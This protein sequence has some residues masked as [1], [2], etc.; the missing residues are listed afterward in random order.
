MTDKTTSQSPAKPQSPHTQSDV[1]VQQTASQNTQQQPKYYNYPSPQQG[2]MHSYYQPMMY[3]G[4]M[5]GQVPMQVPVGHT[6]PAAN[7]PAAATN[8]SAP[9]AAQQAKKAD[10]DDAKRA[11]REA[12]AKRA[13]EKKAKADAAAGIVTP[14]AQEQPK[15][16]PNPVAVV[17]PVVVEEKEEQ[18]KKEAIIEEPKKEDDDEVST[19]KSIDTVSPSTATETPITIE[20]TESVISQ[21]VEGVAEDVLKADTENVEEAENIEAGE[22]A[23]GEAEEEQE[24]TPKIEGPTLSEFLARL[25]NAKP[26]ESVYKFEYPE[27]TT[28]PAERLATRKKR[29]YDPMFLTQFAGPCC[30]FVDKEYMATHPGI[31]AIINSKESAR[32]NSKGSRGGSNKNGSIRQ[33]TIRGEYERSSRNGSK[34]RQPSKRGGRESS[35]RDKPKKEEV[36]MKIDGTPMV[37]LKPE[38][39]VPLEKSKSRWVPKSQKKVEKEVKYAPDG[40][41]VILDDDDIQ[42]KV[43]SLLNKMTLDNLDVIGDE[44]LELANQSLWEDDKNALNRVIEYTFAKAFDEPHW[45]AMYA[46]WTQKLLKEVNEDIGLELQSATGEISSIKGPNLVYRII[47]KTCQVE[48][49]KGWSNS[50]PTNEDGSPL[51]IE[52]MSDEYYEIAKAKRRGL[53]LVRFIGELY[54]LNI[55]R[56]QILTSSLKKLM[57]GE[58]KSNGD[59]YLPEDDTLETILQLLLTA[60]PRLTKSQPSV[61]A[62]VFG[63]IENYTNNEKLGARIRFKFLDLLDSYKVGWS[64]G[65]GID[66]PKTIK[67]IHAA[68]EQKRD[69][70]KRDNSKRGGQRN[71]S[72]NGSRW[73]TSDVGKMGQIRSSGN[74]ELGPRKGSNNL[75]NLR[76][77]VQDDGFT[78]VGGRSKSTRGGSPS[79]AAPTTSTTTTS[80]TPSAGNE[81]GESRQNSRNMFSQLMDHEDE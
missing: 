21:E 70:D 78:S 76:R 47:M 11:F 65:K 73:G 69:S 74:S 48:F 66:G 10:Q 15:E 7:S 77:G 81:E 61:A 75:H 44:L 42:K 8:T 16:E 22:A 46:K 64:D 62:N 39:V 40:V 79:Q 52:M 25:N 3:Y 2:A 37:K 80:Q 41:T 17:T 33:G 29:S 13:A 32:S 57:T 14:V 67:E 20:T 35:K 24:E 6:V 30:F 28:L 23:E 9:P 59:D 5:P 58:A 38:E 60:G 55:L 34:R 71:E 56:E 27:G 19:E 45:S 43:K 68:V 31:T 36:I 50:L 4:Y 72:R 54:K 49:E 63:R 1:P 18:L 26:V 12:I 51:E 53:G